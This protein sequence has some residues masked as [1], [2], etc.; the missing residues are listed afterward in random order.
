MSRQGTLY[1]EGRVRDGIE[2]QN[3][4]KVRE[5]LEAQ[6]D[7]PDQVFDIGEELLVDEFK[8]PL[9]FGDLFLVVKE[10]FQA[11]KVVEYTGQSYQTCYSSNNVRVKVQIYQLYYSREQN[12]SIHQAVILPMPHID[13]EGQW[14]E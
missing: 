13:F 14:D 1:I 7:R 6:L 5:E 9:L 8:A 11:V 4:Q 10:V 3:I 2:L 12:E